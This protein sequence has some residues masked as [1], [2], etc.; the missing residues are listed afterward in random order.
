MTP[1]IDTAPASA[2]RPQA[3]GPLVEALRAYHAL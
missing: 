1:P 3:M 2:L